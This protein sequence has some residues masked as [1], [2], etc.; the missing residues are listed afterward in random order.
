MLAGN[1]KCPAHQDHAMLSR[2]PVYPR[3][4]VAMLML[5][6]SS[7]QATSLPKV[8]KEEQNMQ[9]KISFGKCGFFLENP[10]NDKLGQFS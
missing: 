9:S 8:E 7:W 3:D 4:G 2:V 6:K 1:R 5:V 10:M